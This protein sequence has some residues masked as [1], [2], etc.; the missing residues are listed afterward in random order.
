MTEPTDLTLLLGERVIV[1]GPN[2]STWAGTL[3]ALAD[4]PTA[5]ID[6][7]DGGRVSLP[8]SH[9]Y[10]VVPRPEDQLREQLAAATTRAEHAEAD[11]DAAIDRGDLLQAQVWDYRQRLLDID[12]HATPYGVRA[13]DPDGNP[14]AYLVTVGSLHPALGTVGHTAPKCDAE[15]RAEQAEANL[16]DEH[17]TAVTRA[18]D[19]DRAR[20]E[21]RAAETRIAAVR[22]EHTT[23]FGNEYGGLECST[24]RE[25]WPCPTVT[26]LDGPADTPAAEP[27]GYCR[28]CEGQPRTAS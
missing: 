13:D 11:R 5:V 24:C 18:H 20:R 10:T 15:A 21:L 22:A 2:G 12:A 16:A 27:V 3:T 1:T 28:T 8:Q 7:A 26:A 17:A 9:T 4:Q 25:V 23:E 19:T 6:L 14:T